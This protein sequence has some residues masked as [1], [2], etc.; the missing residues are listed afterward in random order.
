M[1]PPAASEW[2][3]RRSTCPTKERPAPSAERAMQFGAQQ[4]LLQHRGLWDL[5]EAR[6]DARDS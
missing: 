6:R 4:L 3:H 1:R 5:L 2:I